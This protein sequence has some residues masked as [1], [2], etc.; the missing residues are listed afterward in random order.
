M[1]KYQPMRFTMDIRRRKSL[2]TNFLMV[3]CLIFVIIPFIQLDNELGLFASTRGKISG[4]IVDAQS[5]EP[6]PGVNV[7]LVGT[8]MGAATDAN[9]EY[10]IAN[11]PVGVYS[12][13]A[14]MIGYQEVTITNVHVRINGTTEAVFSLSQ[15]ALQSE[16]IVITAERPPIEFDNT[17]T[18]SYLNAT[19]IVAQP[20]KVF[21]EVLTTLPSINDENGVLKFRGGTLDQVAFI[22]DGARVR[23]PM[24]HT[25]YTDLNLSSIQEV[26][27]VTGAFNAEYGE[28]QSGVVNVIT[29]EGSKKYEFYIDTRYTPPGKKHWGLPLYDQNTDLYWENT[30]ARHVEWWIENT[31]QWVDEQGNYGY[32]ADCLWTPEEAYQ[33]YLDTHQPLSDYTNTPTYETEVSLGGPFPLVKNLSFYVT[34]RYRSLAP[35]FGNAYNDKG[36]FFDGTLKLAYQINPNMKLIVSGLYGNENTSWGVEGPPDFFYASNY[37][38]DSRYAYYDYVGLPATT[39]SN[40]SMI[41][42]HIL[43]KSTLYEFRFGWLN[44][45]RKV[46]TFPDDPIGWAATGPTYDNLRAVDDQGNPIIGGYKNRIGYHTTGYYYRFDDSNTEWDMTGFIGSQLSKN[47][48][49]KSGFEFTYYSLDHLN[50]SKLPNRTDQQVYKPYQGA[51]YGQSKLE[52]AGLIMNFG[53]R[54]DFYNPNDVIYS[55]LF[56]PL[57]S[58]TSNTKI[59]TQLSPRLGISHP[60]DTKTVLHFSYGHFF[61]RASFGD[62]GEGNDGGFGS[63]TTFI[64]DGTNFPWVLGNRELKPQKTIAYEVGLERNFF[65]YLIIK[66]TGY[67]KD[68]KNTIRV[69]TIQTPTGIYSTNSNGDYADVS[70]IELSGNLLPI[71]TGAGSFWGYA[72]YTNQAG[73]DGKSGAPVSISY[74]GSVQYAGSG[75]VIMHN[76]PRFKGGIFYQTPSNWN[77]FFRI[78]NDIITSLNYYM[79][80]P[81]D[82]LRSDYFL[83]EGEKYLRPADKTGDL[84]IRKNITIK[85]PKIIISPYLEVRNLFNDKWLYLQAFESTSVEDQRRFVES[86]FGYI[87]TKTANGVTILDMG[88]YRNI[89]RYYL[90]GISLQF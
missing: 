49:L 52:Y 36:T 18:E 90:L 20:T 24:D 43:S 14:S 26:E 82:M 88:K 35:L 45:K 17:S 54:L 5:K 72:N 22:V 41:F 27:V 10:F 87:P 56:D 50:Q 6:L 69:T 57:N 37:G 15:E 53:L 55:N 74:D 13:T 85:N 63:L 73:I 3:S 30:H 77:F 61:Q 78:F 4:K 68:I 60:I 28:A 12:I 40:L 19:Q 9:G 89:P 47:L 7:L 65:D 75:D 21:T 84:R 64:V 33:Q 31:D 42:S 70:G 81:N 80:F 86:D 8:N 62:Y 16:E 29:K 51:I 25:P 38:I 79:T 67:Y 71:R 2:F 48:Y 23:N 44:A 32:E 1:D 34:G 59:F 11:V 46:D 39:T 76:N 58:S 66:L 83:F